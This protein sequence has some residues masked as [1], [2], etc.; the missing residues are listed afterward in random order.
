MPFSSL[1][2]WLT[3]GEE[4]LGLSR[5]RSAGS[6]RHVFP[7]THF[8]NCSFCLPCWRFLYCSCWLPLRFFSWLVKWQRKNHIKAFLDCVSTRWT[9][10]SWISISMLK[11]QFPFSTLFKNL[12]GATHTVGAEQWYLWWLDWLVSA[13][14]AHLSTYLELGQTESWREE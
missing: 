3:I 2:Y 9:L 13:D 14:L 6:E 1:D 12:C 7:Y 11:P 8:F 10:K 4:D 5:E